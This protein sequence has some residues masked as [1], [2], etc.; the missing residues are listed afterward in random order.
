MVGAQLSEQ[1]QVIFN[2][3][4][5]TP[6]SQKRHCCV[7]SLRNK[8]RHSL[9]GVVLIQLN[10]IHQRSTQLYHTHKTNVGETII[11]FNTTFKNHNNYALHSHK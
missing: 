7:K 3:S 11:I 2:N 4:L 5:D 8:E 1:K 10:S 6:I 9:H